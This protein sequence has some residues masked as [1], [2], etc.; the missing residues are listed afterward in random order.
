MLQ[1]VQEAVRNMPPQ[2]PPEPPLGGA[3]MM[4]RAWDPKLPGSPSTL[5]S[6]TGVKKL[7]TD[8]PGHI[9]MHVKYTYYVLYM[10]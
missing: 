6:S 2:G 9:H 10:V 7:S 8:L 4:L 1:Q 3:R 5:A